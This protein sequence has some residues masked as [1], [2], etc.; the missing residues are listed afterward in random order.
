[1]NIKQIRTDDELQAAFQ[2]L[3]TIFQ[4]EGGT[5]EAEERDLLVTE[6]ER[7][8]ETHPSISGDL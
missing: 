8:E 5:R 6:I 1:M 2:R 7:Y 4:A 3:E